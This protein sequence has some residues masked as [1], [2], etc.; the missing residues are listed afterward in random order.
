MEGVG[1]FKYS[2]RMFGGKWDVTDAHVHVVK[3]EQ[4]RLLL[5]EIAV[6]R[7]SWNIVEKFERLACGDN[8][9]FHAALLLSHTGLDVSEGHQMLLKD[10]RMTIWLVCGCRES[11]YFLFGLKKMGGKSAYM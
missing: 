7:C 1:I 9:V 2:L 5:G 8:S 3:N 4:Q 11:V 6:C 10:H